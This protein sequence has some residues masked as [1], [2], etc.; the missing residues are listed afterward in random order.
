MSKFLRKVAGA[1]VVLD[2]SPSTGAEPPLPP[3]VEEIT[4]ETSSLLAQLE[5]RVPSSDPSAGG[6]VAGSAVAGSLLDLTAEEVFRKQAIEDS[7]NSSL[8]LL[9]LIAGISMFP[10]EQQLAMVRAMDLADDTW[11]EAAVVADA[12]RRQGI[13][14][15]HLNNVAA[16]RTQ[17]TTALDQ[18]IAQTRQSGEAVL[19]ELDQ[20]IAVLNARREQEAQTTASAI[21]QLEQQK[22]E[23]E[24]QERRS[25]QGTAQVIQ[26]L[27]GLLSFLGAAPASGS[28]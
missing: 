11:T 21:A 27:A 14:R 5:T 16:E 28:K 24:Q 6:V 19:A 18:D 3:G 25:C 4:R 26:A 22:H 1:F 8:R 12:R 9:K 2:E 17:R 15:E 10:K 13:L 20:R 23:L 7:P